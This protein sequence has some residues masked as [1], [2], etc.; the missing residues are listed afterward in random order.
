M[1]DYEVETF[2]LWPETDE[3]LT[4]FS[5]IS[6]QWRVGFGGPTGLDYNVLFKLLDRKGLSGR[7]YDR[8][9]N[10]IRV[11]EAEALTIMNAK[12]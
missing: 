7:D 8:L 9:F 4:L 6:T 1:D 11:M 12:K 3:A 2:E 5:S 10:D